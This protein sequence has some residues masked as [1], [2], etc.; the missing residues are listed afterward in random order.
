MEMPSLP[1]TQRIATA[2]LGFVNSA[3]LMVYGLGAVHWTD[4]QKAITWAAA[5][6][7]VG[8][9]VSLVAHFRQG[10]KSEPAAVSGTTVA[11]VASVLA[12][13]AGF[14]W[15][16]LDKDQIA[17][18]VGVVTSAFALGGAFFVRSNVTP[19]PAGYPFPADGPINA[20]AFN[21]PPKSK[22]GS[23]ASVAPQPINVTPAASPEIPQAA[24]DP[25]P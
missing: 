18:I 9:A 2:S 1:T 13:G 7:G 8:L 23:S 15:F 10:T 20:G 19:V 5:N 3:L 16:L 25:T 17:L 6:A 12:L 4:A 24:I 11:F 21:P 22:P 14:R